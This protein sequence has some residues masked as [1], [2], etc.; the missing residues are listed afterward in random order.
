MDSSDVKQKG[1]GSNQIASNLGYVWVKQY[2]SVAASLRRLC[3]K[4]CSI[5][6]GCMRMRSHDLD[7]QQAGS[8]GRSHT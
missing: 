4:S 2:K 3:R 7:R 8:Y 6:C 1:I 5:N